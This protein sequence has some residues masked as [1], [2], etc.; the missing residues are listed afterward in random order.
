MDDWKEPKV[1]LGLLIG[2]SFD[3]LTYPYAS[4][5]TLCS[6]SHRHVLVGLV[7]LVKDAPRFHLVNINWSCMELQVSI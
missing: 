5:F 4:L 3:Y 6:G 7:G 1:T 2:A